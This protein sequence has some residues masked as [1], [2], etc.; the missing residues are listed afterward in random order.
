MPTIKP[1]KDGMTLSHFETDDLLSQLTEVEQFIPAP[2]THFGDSYIP[3]A[4]PFKTIGMQPSNPKRSRLSK[5]TL[6]MLQHSSHIPF[7]KSL[8]AKTPL[9]FRTA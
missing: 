9:S 7:F 6:N 8:N 1:K 2:R 3:Q 5:K 4:S